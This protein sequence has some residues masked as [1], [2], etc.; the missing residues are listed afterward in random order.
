MRTAARPMR[1]RR[2]RSAQIGTPRISANREPGSR[3]GII[4]VSK[5]FVEAVNHFGEVS[6][7]VL[8]TIGEPLHCLREIL[9]PQHSSVLLHLVQ[10]GFQRQFGA[11]HQRVADAASGKTEPQAGGLVQRLSVSGSEL[12]DGASGSGE[13]GVP[14]WRTV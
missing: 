3:R 1:R 10:F 11:G 6:V 14:F 7:K 13:G 9:Y 8:Q 5:H 2:I 4:R 12:E